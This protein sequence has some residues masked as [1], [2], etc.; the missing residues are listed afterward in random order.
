MDFVLAAFIF[1]PF[2]CS[3]RLGPDRAVV[4]TG[5]S[6]PANNVDGSIIGK[7]NSGVGW[8]DGWKVVDEG[9]EKGGTKDGALWNSR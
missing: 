3:Q 4:M 1:N 9:W 2:R 7:E 8:K 6:I 5:W